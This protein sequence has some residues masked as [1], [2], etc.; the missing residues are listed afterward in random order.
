MGI[1]LRALRFIWRRIADVGT[2][3]DV[4][5]FIDLKTV[6]WGAVVGFFA[7]IGLG[8]L[9]YEWSPATVFIAALVA[10]ILAALFALLLRALWLAFKH[11]PAKVADVVLQSNRPAPVENTWLPVVELFDL[12]EKHYGWNFKDPSVE[13]LDFIYGLRDAG[14]HKTV[15]LW[16]K[17]NHGGFESTTRNEPMG[18]INKSHWGSYELDIFK[19]LN[20]HDNF[21]VWSLDKRQGGN[22][23]SG[24]YADIHVSHDTAVNWLRDV[25]NRYKGH[26]K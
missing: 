13:I 11:R 25:A 24:G 4:L 6:V 17:K 26:T 16:G 20:T 3:A 15:I 21:Y 23:A 9:N 22:I 2:A 8:A 5:D 14:L 19:A 7:M 1:I 18:V 10:A 12:A